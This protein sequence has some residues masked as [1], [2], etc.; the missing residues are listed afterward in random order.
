MMVLAMTAARALQSPAIRHD[1]LYRVS[2]LHIKA[3]PRA[4]VFS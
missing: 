3:T 1:E 2:D 4:A